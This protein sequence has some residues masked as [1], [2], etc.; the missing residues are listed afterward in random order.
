LYAIA[1]DSGEVVWAVQADNLI[2]TSPAVV[3]EWIF[4]GSHDVSIYAF[5]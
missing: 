3:G 1:R 2:W 4:L 5:R